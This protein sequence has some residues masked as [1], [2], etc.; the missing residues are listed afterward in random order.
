MRVLISGGAGFLGSILTP[1]L[2]AKNHRIAV[3]DNFL[4]GQN[5]LADCCADPNFQ[6]IRGDCRDVN[7]VNE[8]LI[9]TDFF[10]PLAAI[11]GAPACDRDPA[12]AW[13]TNCKAITDHVTKG[14]TRGLK[15]IMP[16][17]NSGYGVGGEAACDENSPLNPLSVYGRSKVEAERDVLNYDGVTLRF[18]TLFGMS[19]RM[20]TDLLVNDFTLRALRDRFVVLFEA[21]FRRNYLHVRDAAHAI[22]W[23]MENYGD[24]SGKAYNVGLPDA[25]LTKWELCEK[26]KEHIPDFYFAEAAVGKDPDQRDYEVS[27]T[28]ILATGWR[29][30]HSLDDGIRELIKGYEI[31]KT[32][33]WA[34]A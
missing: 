30:E 32:P 25:N 26:I 13:Q 6:L 24:M 1:M 23:A 21:H 18:A 14:K 33:R 12:L 19:P 11:V 28:R 10:I 15:I 3:L 16:M 8:L 2:L 9:G 27:N 20:R 7:L 34:N 31:L 22:M 5:S 29:P 4:Y 17:T